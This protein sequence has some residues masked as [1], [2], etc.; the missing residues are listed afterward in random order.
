MPVPPQNPAAQEAILPLDG[1]LQGS[2]I[3]AQPKYRKQFKTWLCLS[4]PGSRLLFS[5]VV[6]L[7]LAARGLLPSSPLAG[8]FWSP[9]SVVLAEG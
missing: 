4:R 2:H 3:Q 9:G 8:G 7:P 1:E 6:P 5:T